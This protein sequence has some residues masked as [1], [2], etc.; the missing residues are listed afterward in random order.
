MKTITFSDEQ[1]F[2]VRRALEDRIGKL[3]ELEDTSEAWVDI[4]AVRVYVGVAKQVLL[5]V[6]LAEQP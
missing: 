3:E 1:L 5:A 6:Q 4:P 2:Q